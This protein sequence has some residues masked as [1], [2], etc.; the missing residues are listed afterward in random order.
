MDTDLTRFDFL[1]NN[2]LDDELKSQYISYIYSC[3]VANILQ[4][5]GIKPLFVTGYSMGI[6]G[7]LYY[8]GAYGFEDG[9][10]LV[11]HAWEMIIEATQEGEYGMGMIVGLSEKDILGIIGND[12][13]VMICNRNNPHTYI[14][15]GGKG[16]VTRVLSAAAA[17]GALRANPLPVTKPYHTEMLSKAVPG[18][19]AWVEKMP[20]KNPDYPYMSSL[21]QRA[22]VSADDLKQELTGNLSRRMNWLETMNVLIE[23]GTESFFECGAG[24]GMTRNFRFIDGAVKAFSVSQLEGFIL[25]AS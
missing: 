6:Y 21:S 19:S 8:C 25:E 14:I 22:L 20:V 1:E 7:A 11:K 16:S 15:S 12:N 2:F 5:R 3:T 10:K 17:E 23:K 9:L 4:K 18:F 13:R 24:D